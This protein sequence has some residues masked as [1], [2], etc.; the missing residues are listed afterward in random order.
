MDADSS[1]YHL[2]LYQH[3]IVNMKNTIEH[4]TEFFRTINEQR[5]NLKKPK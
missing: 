4:I 2:I 3:S 1:L 5:L